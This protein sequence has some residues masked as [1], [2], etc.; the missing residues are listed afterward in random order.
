[1]PLA[2]E[3]PGTP[4]KWGH[5]ETKSEGERERERER[6]REKRERE[7]EERERKRERGRERERERNVSRS[8]NHSLKG[9]AVRLLAESVLRF[10]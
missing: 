7:R 10:R 6:K 4:E 8:S 2:A 5:Q 1:M 9:F 3:P